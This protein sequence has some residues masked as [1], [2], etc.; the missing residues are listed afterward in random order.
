M[1]AYRQRLKDEAHKVAEDIEREA[2]AD[3]ERLERQVRQMERRLL[4]NRYASRNRKQDWKLLMKK[5]DLNL[6]HSEWKQPKFV[7]DYLTLKKK[8]P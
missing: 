2:T 6:R 5:G 3:N 8:D 4:R 7:K 1:E